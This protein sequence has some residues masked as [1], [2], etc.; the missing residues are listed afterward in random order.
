MREWYW[1]AL[2]EGRKG[3]KNPI[4]AGHLGLS[5]EN[6]M[7]RTSIIRILPRNSAPNCSIR[8]IGPTSSPAPGAKYVALTSSKHHEGFALW[9]SKREA[10]C[11]LGTSLERRRYWP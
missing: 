8:I 3:G 11:H 5:P 4:D 7:A 10:S 6:V 1:H 9:P 2:T